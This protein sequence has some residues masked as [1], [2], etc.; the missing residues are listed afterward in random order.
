MSLNFNS[1]GS[2]RRVNHGS[3]AGL[4]DLAVDGTMTVWAWVYREADGSNQMVMGKDGAYPSGWIFLCDNPSAEGNIRLIVFRGAT[5]GNATDFVSNASNVVALNTPTFIAATLDTGAGT[6]VKLYKGTV[7]SDVAEVS[8]YTTSTNGTGAASTD[9]SYDMMVGNLQRTLN[10]P[11][12]GRI[13][14][15]GVV[16][17]VLTQ[18]QLLSIQRATSI[19]GCNVTNTQ[20]LFNYDDD[21]TVDHSGNGNTGTVTSAVD[22]ADLAFASPP[23]TTNFFQFFN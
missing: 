7:A 10:T 11:F 4:D 19:S 8:G 5:F 12:L 16:N 9:A 17:S 15:G 22:D 20:L 18:A 13:H 23:N 6:Y 3:A 2:G 21:P 14:R 1:A